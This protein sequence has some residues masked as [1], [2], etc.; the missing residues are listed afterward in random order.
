VIVVDDILT[1]G[2]TLASI[3][4][5]LADAGVRVDGAA[6]IAATRR[7]SL[8]PNRVRVPGQRS[9]VGFSA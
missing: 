4:G 8:S 1:T 7:R 2:S 9:D 5:T 3:A 6:T